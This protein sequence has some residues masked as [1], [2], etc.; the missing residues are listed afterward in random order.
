[1]TDKGNIVLHSPE[2][3]LLR[4]GPFGTAAAA[5]S[6]RTEFDLKNECI[7]SRNLAVDTVFIGDSITHF[8]ELP[9]YFTAA[10][11]LIINRGIA[12]DTTGFMVRRFGGDAVQLHPRRVIILA[13]INDL[14]DLEAFPWNIDP[15][16]PD[17]VALAGQVVTNL[18]R[19]AEASLN[20]G[21]MPVLCSILPTSME[22]TTRTAERNRLVVRI[23]SEL[24]KAAEDFGVPYVDYHSALADRDG[25]SLRS[26]LSRD[27][28]HPHQ[29]G[30]R[31]MAETLLAGLPDGTTLRSL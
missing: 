13:G 11:G 28:L 4:P 30:Y 2:T 16:V 25:L 29:A 6:R 20:A 17:P 3:A 21:I 5:D 24:R 10:G 19:M 9:A 8:W 14:W 31:V 7:L 12:G 18:R 23:N 22:W 26:G 15:P 27:G 1:M